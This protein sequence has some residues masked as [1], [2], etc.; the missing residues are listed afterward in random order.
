MIAKSAQCL[1]FTIGWRTIS[2]HRRF[3]MRRLA[4]MQA[5]KRETISF[6]DFQH[7]F[8]LPRW[9]KEVRSC[10]PT[11]KLGWGNQVNPKLLWVK[12]K[13][14]P[15]AFFSPV[16]H[17]YSY[18]P[19]KTAVFSLQRC[20]KLPD[21]ETRNRKQQSVTRR[22]HRRERAGNLW[23]HQMTK[24]EAA[25][26]AHNATKAKLGSLRSKW[27]CYGVLGNCCDGVPGKC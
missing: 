4:D 23:R 16:N 18:T 21:S 11:A 20:Q 22:L 5:D 24:F 12:P 25:R 6:S 9:C 10:Q 19:P 7:R 17:L 8:F 14:G 13:K 26:A 3:R 27:E 2:G 1:T 15:F